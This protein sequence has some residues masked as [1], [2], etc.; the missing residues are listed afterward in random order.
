M[1]ERLERRRFVHHL[2]LQRLSRAEVGTFLASVHGKVPPSGLIDALYGRTGGNP[3]FLEEILNVAGDV[4]P[5]ELD[6]QPLPW[7]LAEL[8]RG[9][10]DGLSPGERRLVEA[11]AILGRRAEFDVLA[12]VT[13]TSEDELID[14]LRGLLDRGLLMEECEDSFTFRHALLRDAV[15]Q[16]L[17]GRERRRL[18]EVALQALRQSP[19]EDL[20]ALAHH[21]RGAGRYDALVALACKGPGRIAGVQ[22]PGAAQARRLAEAPDDPSCCRWR[23]GRRCSASTTRRWP[24]SSSGT[25]WPGRAPPATGGGGPHPG[26]STTRWTASTSWRGPCRA[27]G[28][29]RELERARIRPSPWRGWPSPHGRP[30]A[31]TPSSGPSGPSPR[32]AV[33]ARASG[34]SARG[35]GLGDGRASGPLRRRRRRRVRRSPKP[36]RWRTG[37]WS[38]AINNEHVCRSARRRTALLGRLEQANE[39]AG[40]DGMSGNHRFRLAEFA[41]IEGNLGEAHRQLDS[42]P[43]AGGPHMQASYH[44]LDGVVAVEE[45]RIDDAAAAVAAAE[46]DNRPYD[47]AM[48]L[49]LALVVASHRGDAAEVVRC[50]DAVLDHTPNQRFHIDPGLIVDRLEALER[51]GLAA[52]AAAGGRVADRC[53]PACTRPCRWARGALEE[54]P[55]DAAGLGLALEDLDPRGRATSAP[56]RPGPGPALLATG[57]RDRRWSAA[58]RPPTWPGG[59]AG[60]DRSTP[61]STGSAAAAAG[62]GRRRAHRPGAGGGHPAGRGVTNAELARR[63]YI[64]PKT[65]AVHVSNIP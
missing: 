22:P 29:G 28:A 57:R 60:G 8:V 18:H 52:R 54:R 38:W 42:M 5:T 48:F 41:I 25:G 13:G 23:R 12:D 63:L 39:R 45:G 37:C 36:R 49:S 3:F 34:P 65:A 43:H 26:S 19:C 27:G 33:G 44:V 2:Q 32:P 64:S 6:R 20:A 58:R 61:C 46:P 15:E 1:L 10:L 53:C 21:A 40:F 50:V 16:Q 14:V 7:S 17:L 35:A 30:A 51:A 47:Q 24:T 59:R 56:A 31:R 4:D 11:A 62:G 9:Q 55:D